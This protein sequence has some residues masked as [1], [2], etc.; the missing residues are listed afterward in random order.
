MEAPSII[1]ITI[2]CL[3]ADHLG[4]YGY[5]RNTSP[6]IDSLAAKGVKFLEAI[7]NGGNTPAAFPSILASALPPLNVPEVKITLQS[8][9]PLAEI[10]RNAGYHTAAFHS[11]PYLL[12]FHGYDRGFDT[13]Q[14]NMDEFVSG[15]GG[16][17]RWLRTPSQLKS[18]IGLFARFS[19][20]L[21]RSL[22]DP[23]VFGTGTALAENINNQVIS[24]LK[25]CPGKFFLWI[26]YMDVHQ[27]YL[28][29]PQYINQFCTQPIGRAELR[30][31]FSKLRTRQPELSS[32]E[33]VTLI[34]LYDAEINYTDNCI[35]LLLNTLLSN[36]PNTVTIVTADHGE[37]FSEHG[38]FGHSTLYE[39]VVRVPLIM[40]GPDIKEGTVIKE[41]VSPIDLAPTIAELAGIGGIPSFYG[42]SLLPLTRGETRANKGI[43][44]VSFSTNIANTEQFNYR[45]IAYR[46]SNW[47]YIRTENVDNGFVLG[48][49]TYY[50]TDDPYEKKNLHGTDN[51]E[52]N[53]F[54][55][56]AKREIAQ[57]KQLKAEEA[58]NYEKQR[59]KAK[60]RNLYSK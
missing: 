15:L 18:P 24:W 40:A 9:I 56:E 42:Q 55:S 3:R 5:H 58:T 31:L 17:R 33:V 59:I 2:D 10:L 16:F 37:E 35:G 20:R 23:V 32:A 39:G 34:D 45:I 50:L 46:T 51:K 53:R 57:F 43:I 54:E 22:L 36:L 27:P 41:Q 47:K 1:L 7:S 6:N 19:S 30:T 44:S 28:V 38:T 11:N 52:I 12:S 29:P 13:F 49:E 25:T 4:C 48:E 26:H 14:D 21:A 8:S 60:L